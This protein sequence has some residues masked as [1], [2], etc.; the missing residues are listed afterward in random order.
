MALFPSPPP[1]PLSL[2]PPLP[3]S[4]LSP[5]PPSVWLHSALFVTHSLS[6]VSQSVNA[7]SATK[8]DLAEFVSVLRN[9][10]TTAVKDAGMNLKGLIKQE[11]V[12][13]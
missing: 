1:P 3:L 5:S 11:D 13:T 8:R 4:P 7:L 6:S 10:T 9:D 2:S 12:C